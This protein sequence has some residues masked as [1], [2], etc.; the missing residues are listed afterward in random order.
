[1]V[2]SEEEDELLPPLNFE[3]TILDPN[4]VKLE[5]RPN[6]VR[7]EDEVFYVVNIK[8]LTTNSPGA[9]QENMLRQQVSTK[10]R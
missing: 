8:Q 2:S 3:A 7:G 9:T 6:A 10:L 5:W 1:M 4:S